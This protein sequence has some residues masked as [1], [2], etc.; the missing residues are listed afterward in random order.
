V[1]RVYSRYTW[2]PYSQQSPLCIYIHK[3]PYFFILHTQ[4]NNN[5]NINNNNIT[6]RCM[7]TH[8]HTHTHTQALEWILPICTY[9]YYQRKVP[10]VFIT[11]SRLVQS[12][13]PCLN[14][15]STHQ[16]FIFKI[17]IELSLNLRYKILTLYFINYNNKKLYLHS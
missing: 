8:T 4:L 7:H 17:N 13:S 10:L 9:C 2:K 6:V 3:K 15:I 16:P 5:N 11:V 12:L 14:Y 1:T